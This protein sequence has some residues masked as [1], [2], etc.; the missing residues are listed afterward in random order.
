MGCD[1]SGKDLESRQDQAGNVLT[2]GVSRQRQ[3]ASPID[4]HIE[5]I[6]RVGFTILHNVLDSEELNRARTGIDNTYEVQVQE[7]GDEARLRSINDA[8]IARSL[9]VY[10]DFFLDRVA[11]NA[12]VL[13]IVRTFLGANISLSSQVGILSRPAN[14]LYQLA[15]HRELQYQHFVS[16]KPLA[17]Q[18]LF[19][20]D[21]FSA[22]S[23][24]TFVLPGS[25]LIEEFPSDEFVREHETQICAPAG[26]A[27]VFNSMLYH[28]AGANAGDST[29][30]AIN[31]LYTLPI[32]QQQINFAK[33]LGGRHADDPFLRGLL[34]YEWSTADSVLDWRSARLARLRP[35]D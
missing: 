16:S 17:I 11:V 32:I 13:D 24:G 29:R 1:G 34:G 15:W 26:S 18:S 31:N 22:T 10:N 30:R 19:C 5:E 12:A 4:R 25:H 7:L 2:H 28:R 3:I 14:S 20:I 35:R 8:D 33:M 6:E 21:E 23:G 9:L 27:L